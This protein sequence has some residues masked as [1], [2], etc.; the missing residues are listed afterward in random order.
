MFKFF[1]FKENEIST[2]PITETIVFKESKFESKY[3]LKLDYEDPF[4][5]DKKIT[6]KPSRSTLAPKK[7]DLRF[8]KTNQ[9]KA[10]QEAPEIWPEIFYKG[11]GTNKSRIEETMA[12]IEF[13]GKMEI[14][15]LH[16]VLNGYKVEQIYKDSLLISKEGKFKTYFKKK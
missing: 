3:E 14:V 15:N 1:G 2:V 10:I 8:K 12:W 7:K 11:M 13:N 16:Q 4:L 5:K 6:K 9:E